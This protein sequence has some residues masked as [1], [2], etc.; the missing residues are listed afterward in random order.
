MMP[1][2]T[3]SLES[4]DVAL[5][6]AL[7]KWA[8]P[9]RPKQLED[10]R[11]HFASIL[12]TNRRFNL[13]RITDP[14]AAAVKHYA[15]S[16]ALLLWTR[17]CSVEVGTVLDI[18]TGAGFPAVPLAVMRPDWSITAVDATGK[19][20][21]FVARVS[22]TLHLNN[23]TVEHAHS[24]HWSPGQTFDVV[25][26]RAVARLG[27]MFRNTCRHASPGGWLIAYKGETL[28]S[29]E[30]QAASRAASALR[31]ELV[32]RYCYDLELG[33]ETLRRTLHI[34]RRRR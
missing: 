14:I 10:L 24:A 13:T 27:E 17:G 26:F 23:L 8:V 12:E 32:D 31:L 11:R 33:G 28:A 29:G 20:T 18:G 6:A 1:G 5:Q 16:L 4:F 9:I 15:D 22:A 34:Y 3:A 7:D 30:Q 2:M 25:I 21:D 19:K